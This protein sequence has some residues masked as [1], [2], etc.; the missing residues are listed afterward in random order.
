M[1]Q[2]IFLICAERWQYARKVIVEGGS[3]ADSMFGVS[4]CCEV[5]QRLDLRRNRVRRSE[6]RNDLFAYLSEGLGVWATFQLF[7]AIYS[8]MNK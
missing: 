5:V 2:C 1:I 8:K 3:R 4:G 7:K 6:C